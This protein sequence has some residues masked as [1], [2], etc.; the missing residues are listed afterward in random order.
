MVDYFLDAF[1]GPSGLFMWAITA[2]LAFGIAVFLERTWL[3]LVRWRFDGAAL[4]AAIGRGDLDAAVRLAGRNP[5]TDLLEAGRNAGSAEAAWDV[6]SAR[7]VEI[8]ARVNRR[9]PYLAT[10]GNVSTMVGLLGNVLGIIIAFGSLGDASAEARAVH[11]SQGIA[12]AMA[13]TAWGLLVAIPALAAHAWLEQQARGLLAQVEATAGT[14]AAR[15]RQ[16]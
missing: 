14:L 15:L 16:G 4:R 5:V 1:A 6:M 8:E 2:I 9:I 11:L 12:T 13:T 10:I 3:L 7:A